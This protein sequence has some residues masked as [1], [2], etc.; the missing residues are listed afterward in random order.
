MFPKRPMDR[1]ELD[2]PVFRAFHKYQTVNFRTY[3]G[4]TKVDTVG[5][6]ELFGVNLGCR[7]AVLFSPHDLSCGWDEHTHD[8]GD[9]LLPGDAI[10]LGINIVSYVAAL[11]QVAEVQSVTREI[12]GKNERKRAAVRPRPT[13]PPGRLGPRPQQ[14]GA[15]APHRLERVEPRGRLRPAAGGRRRRSSS[16]ST[17]SCT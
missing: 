17:R 12:A 7:A 5:P 6:P 14:H 4:A 8:H 2:H 16:R 15:V 13:A 11:R 9:R 3:R 1:L 10:R